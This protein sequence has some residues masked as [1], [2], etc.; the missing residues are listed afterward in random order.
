SRV[1]FCWST[2]CRPRSGWCEAG[3]WG[4]GTSRRGGCSSASSL[5]CRRDCADLL[6]MDLTPNVHVHTVTSARV[7]R[8]RWDHVSDTVLL[9]QAEGRLQV[10]AGVRAGGA[11]GLGAAA[12][13]PPVDVLGD[14]GCG[15]VVPRDSD[16]GDQVEPAGHG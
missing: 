6:G 12:T 2:S 1:W 8:I 9:A 5:G 14:D 7:S 16:E 10:V 15:V 11:V 13:R 3:R 4:R